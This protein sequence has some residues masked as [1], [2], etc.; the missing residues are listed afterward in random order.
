MFTSQ[1]IEPSLW[2]WAYLQSIQDQ[3]TTTWVEL[4]DKIPVVYNLNGPLSEHDVRYVFEDMYID[5][6]KE[7]EH[8]TRL[9]IEAD[10]EY[11][12]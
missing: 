7:V 2:P 1:K 12:L 5:L 3:Q 8:G 10:G 9:S 4:R 11:L 6:A